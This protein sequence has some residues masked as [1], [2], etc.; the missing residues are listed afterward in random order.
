MSSN[1]PP[2]LHY[3]VMSYFETFNQYAT[4]VV[5]PQNVS[6]IESIQQPRSALKTVHALSRCGCSIWSDLC[7]IRY[8]VKISDRPV[9]LLRS[10]VFEDAKQWCFNTYDN[11][12]DGVCMLF[13]H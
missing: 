5:G 1:L 12:Y 9:L 4:D 2:S 3:L 8:S 10:S 13:P 11:K 6:N 7:I